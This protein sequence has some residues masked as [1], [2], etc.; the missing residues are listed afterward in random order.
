MVYVN[1]TDSPCNL[2]STCLYLLWVLVL[3]QKSIMSGA[4]AEIAA[5]PSAAPMHG[6]EHDAY[7][8]GKIIPSPRAFTLVGEDGLASYI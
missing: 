2:I 7:A 1:S 5:P 6:G 3:L 8:F 4:A